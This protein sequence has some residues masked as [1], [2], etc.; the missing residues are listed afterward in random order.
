M[1]NVDFGV[2]FV[3]EC[4]KFVQDHSLE[5]S[6]H[7]VAIKT[8][9][10]QMMLVAVEQIKKRLPS[11]Q[12]MFENLTTISPKII[13]SQ[14]SRCSFTD[15]SFLKLFADK[16]TLLENQHQKFILVDKKNEK[17]LKAEGIPV[18]DPEKFWVS[19]LQHLFFKDLLNMLKFVLLLWLLTQWL[20]EFF[21]TH[22]CKDETKK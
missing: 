16:L 5:R 10:E 12:N 6:R 7:V 21:L 19:I 4:D 11:T 14:K 1:A 20:K 22:S 17:I 18:Y 13:L 3:P 9:C 2:K 8:T 15:L